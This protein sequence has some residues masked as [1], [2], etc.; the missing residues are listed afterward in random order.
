M[1]A[2]PSGPCVK[3][4]R[5]NL[6]IN[7]LQVNIAGLQNKIPEV[8]KTLID[9]DVH[10]ALIQETILP[11]RDITVTGYTQYKCDCRKCQ[12]IMTLVRNDVEATVSNKSENDIDHQSI[13][14]WPRG[15]TDLKLSVHNIYC[16]PSSTSSLPQY[17]TI[18]RRTIIA[19]DFNA[20]LPSLGYAHYNQR[21]TEVEDICNSS[22]LVMLQSRETPPT[23]LHRA[24]GTTSR[25]DLTFVSA[26]ILEYTSIQVLDDV[27]SDHRPVLTTITFPQERAPTLKRTTWN[28]RK[29][30]WDRFAEET[31][32]TFTLLPDNK[33]LKTTC[34]TLCNYILTAAKHTIPRGRRRKYK[35]HWTPELEEAV[36]QRRKARR[37]VE[38][39][40]SA[41]NKKDYNKLTAKVRY[42]VKK[43]K[44]TAWK[45]TCSQLDL[46]REGHK[47]WQLL[48]NLEGSRKN[49]N[50][51]PLQDNHGNTVTGSRRK[52]K[53]FNDF[54]AS[55]NKSQRR[56]IL[57]SALLKARSKRNPADQD[58]APVFDDPFN[59]HELER[60]MRKLAPRKAAGPDNIKNEML[61]HLGPQ[62]KKV[63]LA[64]INRTW[65]EGNLPS[66]WKTA[67]ITPLHKKGKEPGSP[68][69]YRPVSLTSCVGKLVERMVNNRLYWWLESNNIIDSSQAGFRCGCRT[70]DPLFRL[71]QNVMDGFQKGKSTTAVFIDLQQAYDRVWRKGLLLKLNRIGVTGKMHKWLRAFLT[72][73]TIATRYEGALSPKKT[74]EEGLPQGSALSCTL[75]LVYINDLP[76]H[77]KV[78]KALFADDLVIWTSDKY[79]VLTKAKLNRA[80]ATISTYCE[81]WKLKV[82]TQKTTYTIFSRSHKAAKRHINLH[83]NGEPLSKDDSPVYLGVK[84][85]RQMHM[86]EHLNILKERASKRLNLIKRLTSTKWGSDKQTL[87]QLYMGY[88]RS[89]MDYSLPFQ[90]IASKQAATGLDRIQNQAARLICGGMRSTPTAACEIEANLEPLDLR[91]NRALLET[92]ERYRRQPQD[93]PNRQVVDNWREERR[94]QQK[95][96]MDK[97]QEEEEEHHL[98]Q[99]RE[100][101]TKC[102]SPPPWY[103]LQQPTIR[104]KLLQESANKQTPPTTLKIYTLETIDSYPTSAIHAYTDG[105]AFRATKFAGFGFY[106]KYPDGTSDERCDSCG[107]HCSNFEAEL[108]AIKS[109]VELVH[110][111]FDLGEKEKVPLVIFSDSSSALEALRHPPFKS[112]VLNSTAHSLH[113]LI[114]AHNIQITL[115]WIPGHSDIHGNEVADKLAKTGANKEQFENPCSMPTVKQILKSQY[116][117]QWLNRWATGT[118]GRSYFAERPQPKVKDN[119][120]SLNRRNQSLIFQFRTGHAPV[121]YH[122]NRIIPEHEPHCRH[123][124]HPYET[125]S[126]ILFQCPGL[127]SLRKLLPPNPTIHN[128]LYGPLDQLYRTASFIK[129]ALTDKSE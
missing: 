15:K 25:P 53:H 73:R 40:P 44:T 91:R 100:P 128:T 96:L 43:S 23:L 33:D 90:V 80:L 46:N 61:R 117:E 30:K 122:L 57:D 104:T 105:S 3:S 24:H 9:F 6:I 79:P 22:N 108:L 20:H 84:L 103:R 111:Q 2:A 93:H 123:C 41:S 78:S 65:S 82:N 88:V 118:T 97:A 38:K 12:G 16:P 112:K 95:S 58:S 109:A 85:D 106:L 45:D 11:N 1:V 83:L 18:F 48:N 71:V 110:Q 49:T 66:Q 74:L 76:Q 8:L 116:K 35:P 4:A 81:L 124:E 121:H 7:I 120:N 98:P 94:L 10:V 114:S 125:V 92:V 50:P 62:A 101:E 21:G 99:Q 51:Q 42:L 5:G 89:V 52:A 56:D 59:L 26:D 29:A 39:D 115:Q 119:I 34:Q 36:S 69:S 68:R 27:G 77:L 13:Q 17:D 86:T 64:F 55:V 107:N 63:L 129:L 113:N 127:Q 67:I 37:K 70:A 19:G 54:F 47:A 72:N 32:R 126:H 87:R 31:D 14:L 28:F 75:F 60:A 102:P